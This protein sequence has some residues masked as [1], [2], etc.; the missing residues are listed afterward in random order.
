VKQRALIAG[1]LALLIAAPTAEA[2]APIAISKLAPTLSINFSGGDQITAM[3]QGTGAIYLAGTLESPSTALV[4]APSLGASDGFVVALSPSGS[5]L[6]DLRLGGSGD[7][8]ATAI[9][10][11]LIGNIWIAGASA[12]SASSPAPGLNR[13]TIWEVNSAGT[14]INTYLRD[15]PEV[16]VPLSFVAKGANFLIQGITSKAGSASFAA[17]LNPAAKIGPLNYS[18]I[19]FPTAPLL[20]STSSSL[21]NWQ[22]YVTTTPIKGV[23]GISLHQKTTVLARYG[24]KDKALKAISSVTGTPI[25]LQYQSGTGVVLLTQGSGYFLTIIHTK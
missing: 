12:V 4:T 14:L 11:D 3:A 16:D 6:W 19:T 17:T 13:L 25:A 21:Y 15:L 8:V 1:L 24:V 5:H 9:Y 7:D 22:S 10:V 18:S 20:R 2:K 23:T